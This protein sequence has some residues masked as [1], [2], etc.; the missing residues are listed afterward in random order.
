MTKK[1]T[2]TTKS[3]K[4]TAAVKTTKSTKRAKPVNDRIL[5]RFQAPE[6]EAQ[7]SIEEP[8]ATAATADDNAA[9]VAH[10]GDPAAESRQDTTTENGSDTAQPGATGGNP[11][12]LATSSGGQRGLSLVDAAIHVMR[13]TGEAMNTIRMVAL[14]AERG[15]W[16]PSRGGKT[17]AATLY[18]CILREIRDKGDASRF[19]KK[20]RGKFALKG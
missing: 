10:G 14:V 12:S 4:K 8:G 1:S 3:S 18:S 19:E 2:K 20:E 15:L 5:A 17:P 13:E 7:P 11:P 9:P 6:P 16:Q